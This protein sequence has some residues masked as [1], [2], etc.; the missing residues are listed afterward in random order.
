[1]SRYHLAV[2]E[3]GKSTITIIGD[4]GLPSIVNQDHPNYLAI[5][6]GLHRGDDVSSLLNVQK[7]IEELDDRVYVKEDVIYFDDEPVHNTLTRT[8]LR[9]LREGRDTTG[10]V[11]FMELLAEN[12]SKR[13]RECLFDWVQDRDLTIDEEGF[14]IGWKGVRPDMRS[15]NSGTAFVDGEEHTGNIP[16]EVGA[17]I[18]MPRTE[19]MDDPTVACHVGLHVGT[20]DYAKGFGQVLLEVRVNPAHVVSVPTGSESWK[21]RCCEYQVVRIHEGETDQFDEDYEPDSDSDWDD[22]FSPLEDVIP[23][24]FL[25]RVAARLGLKKD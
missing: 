17:I 1:M 7:Q 9:Y 13:G 15:V 3:H 14:F 11:K 2:D 19:V 16:N 8:I 6:L 10:L 21:I 4:D 23:E 24:S 18:T 25:S 12:P 22:D 20:Y 5:S